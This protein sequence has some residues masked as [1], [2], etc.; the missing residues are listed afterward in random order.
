LTYKFNIAENHNF[1]A[2]V[3]TS[4]FKYEDN[5]MY[6]SNVN[7]VFDD[8]KRAWLDNALNTD[9]AQITLNGGPRNIN[10]RMSY[11]GRL[12]YTYKDKYL[13]NATFRADG[14]SQ[15]HQDNRW[16][17]FPSV[18]A[19]WIVTEE[20]FLGNTSWLDFFKLR[21]SWGQVGNQNAGNFQ[22]LSPVT[23]ANTN[24]IFGNEEGVLSP[25]AYPSRYAN[26]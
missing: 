5:Y 17:Y 4:S 21:G 9:G 20:E 16:G 19:G 1:E 14:S 23:F 6:G 25:G 3:G 18:S 24:Y 12:N 2:M 13:L 26:P 22:Y 7:L 15:F 10:K 8:L 11:F